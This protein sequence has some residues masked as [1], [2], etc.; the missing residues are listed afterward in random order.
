MALFS[1]L[2]WGLFV[3][4]LMASV[5]VGVVFAREQ[6]AANDY[7]LA[8]RSMGYVVVAVSVIAALFSGIT[9]LGAP[10]EEERQRSGDQEAGADLP[11]APLAR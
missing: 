10:S 3:A 9:Y 8:G 7:F 2:D 11:S 4:Y 5:L 1:V 6:R